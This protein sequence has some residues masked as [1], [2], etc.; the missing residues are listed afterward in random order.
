MTKQRY[1][2]DN[3]QFERQDLTLIVAVLALALTIAAL[4]TR[5]TSYKMIADSRVLEIG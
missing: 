1:G 3:S 2:Q 4:A 5:Q